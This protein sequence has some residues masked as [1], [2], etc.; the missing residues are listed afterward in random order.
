METY[1]EITAA[2]G[3]RRNRA[4]RFETLTSE[5]GNCQRAIPRFEAD[6]VRFEKS[7]RLLDK[8][9]A[10]VAKLDGSIDVGG[11]TG[12]AR[13]ALATIVETAR[14]DQQRR[15][16]DANAHLARARTALATAEAA[17]RDLS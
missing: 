1:T 16:D 7:V 11:L 15:C 3:E 9:A 17:L 8:I 14:A 10:D 2:D 5:V 12:L 6:A 4:Y 13:P